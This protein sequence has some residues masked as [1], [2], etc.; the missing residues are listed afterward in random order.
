MVKSIVVD[1]DILIDNV[2]GYAVWLDSILRNGG[3]ELVIPSIV[4][5]EYLTAQEVETKIG[6]KRSKEYLS[7]FDVQDLNFE[8]AEILARILRRN[9]YEPGTGIPD[10]IVAS[11]ALFLDAPLATRNRGHFKGIPGLRFFDPKSFEK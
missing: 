2:H 8:I 3:W 4:V 7:N 6:D 10:L 5:A 11:T 1:T 9:T